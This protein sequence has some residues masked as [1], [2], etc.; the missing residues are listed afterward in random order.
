MYG[1]R[2]GPNGMKKE[3]FPGH[4]WMANFIPYF[5]PI[6]HPLISLASHSTFSM[7]ENLMR[8]RIAKIKT[9]K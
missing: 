1:E 3:V 4:E 8:S 9:E 7:A 6:V 5:I 2:D